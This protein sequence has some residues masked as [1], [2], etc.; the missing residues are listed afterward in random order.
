MP[1]ARLVAFDQNA[2]GGSVIRAHDLRDEFPVGGHRPSGTHARL[3]LGEGA[4]NDGVQNQRH[5][6]ESGD[7][8]NEAELLEAH[9]DGEQV[10]AHTDGNA[11]E[12]GPQIVGGAGL[13]GS[14]GMLS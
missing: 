12:T 14:G 9:S 3:V 8:A 4:G 10:E 1:H 13:G 6:D 2:E 11:N 7:G 5:A